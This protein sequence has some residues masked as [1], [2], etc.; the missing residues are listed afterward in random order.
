MQF[1]FMRYGVSI[2]RRGWLE[3]G[4]VLNTLPADKLLKRLKGA[5]LRLS[6]EKT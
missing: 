2:A 1:G 3:K 4:D 6:S 5:K